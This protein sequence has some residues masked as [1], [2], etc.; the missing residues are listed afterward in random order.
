MIATAIACRPELIIA[1]EPTTALDVTIQEQILDLLATCSE[2]AGMAMILVSHDLGVVAQNA[3]RVAVMYAGRSSSTHRRTCS[4]TAAAT[5]TRAG[6]ID[7]LPTIGVAPAA[8]ADPRP[9]ARARCAAAGCPFQPRC[10]I[11]RD[12]C[13][14][15]D[16]RLLGSASSRIACPFVGQAVDTERPAEAM[17]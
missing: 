2:R 5:P 16:M 1:D 12:A 3:D 8:E 9:A 4:W 10:A 14:A 7:A 17:T 11:R 6:L 13:A 15:V